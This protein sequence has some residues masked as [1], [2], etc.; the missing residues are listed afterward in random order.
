VIHLHLVCFAYALL[1]HLR[2]ARTGAQGQRKRDKVVGMSVAAAQEALRGLIWD[3]L[4][5]FLKETRPGESVIE[6]SVHVV[7]AKYLPAHGEV[8][9]NAGS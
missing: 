4:L 2:L 5:T 1:T 9:Y 6:V 8:A 7:G 3:D